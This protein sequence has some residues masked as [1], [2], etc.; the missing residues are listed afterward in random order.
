MSS[1]VSETI[2]RRVVTVAFC[3]DLIVRVPQDVKMDEEHYGGEPKV[4]ASISVSRRLRS[5]G[6]ASL[7][8]RKIAVTAVADGTIRD[9][10]LP[11]S[12]RGAV[13]GVV[14]DPLVLIL[15]G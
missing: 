7:V 6:V 15:T 1:G 9:R 11:D 4:V 8:G 13:L 3:S 2:S 12:I 14:R 10:A 5:L